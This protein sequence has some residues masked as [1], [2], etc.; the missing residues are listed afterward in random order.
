[1]KIPTEDFSYVTLTIGDTM[2]MMFEMA[3]GVMDM[4]TAKSRQHHL[5]LLPHYYYYH[6]YF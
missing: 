1:M 6:E 3:M 5:L 2:E 4:K